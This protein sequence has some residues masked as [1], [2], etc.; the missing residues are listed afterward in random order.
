MCPSSRPEPPG[1]FPKGGAQALAWR[2]AA[3]R[4]VSLVP[5]LTELLA[6]LG[7]DAEVAGLTRFCVHPTGW[8][9]RKAIVGGTKNVDPE[10][11]RPLA[12]DLVLA[13]KEENMREQV[14][15]LEAF[16]PVHLTDI[17]TVPG[18][19]GEIRRIGALVG[20][21]AEEVR[22]ARDELKAMLTAEG[23]AP[24]APFDGLE[25]LLPARDYRNRHASIM[26][27]LD[28]ATAA[29]DEIDAKTPA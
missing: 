27:T 10:K 20:R 29:L 5:S 12:P 18:A 4:I 13:S 19:L 26:L 2:M 6:A 8:K 7:L 28:A 22:A 23:P 14:E 1:A 24:S 11:V 9:A 3:R 17:A 15:A 25:V 21:E 16:A